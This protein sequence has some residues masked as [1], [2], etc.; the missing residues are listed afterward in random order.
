MLFVK[1]GFYC[2]RIKNFEIFVLELQSDIYRLKNFNVYIFVILLYNVYVMFNN[3][4]FP[5]QQELRLFKS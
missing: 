3:L 4:M 2:M 5:S 1:A